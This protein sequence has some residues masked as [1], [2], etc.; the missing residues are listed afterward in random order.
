MTVRVL[1]ATEALVIG[2][3]DLAGAEHH[4]VARVR[5]A[6][7]GDP[8]AA[9]DGAGRV[10]TGAIVA[11]DADRTRIRLDRVVAEPAPVPRITA[12]IPLI[13]GDR[14]DL[15][16]EKLAEV[17]VDAIVLY[18]AA[19]AVVR[20]DDDRAATRRDRLAA[21]A[22]AATRQSGRGAAPVVTGP[23]PLAAALGTVAGHDLRWVA[24]PAAD[25]P[26]RPA[27]PPA[28]LAIL[29]GP[30]GGL[31]ADELAAAA[32]AGF[33]TVGLGPYVLRAE[34]AP[35]VAAAHARLLCAT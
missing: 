3:L 16:V 33:V 35:I 22:E 4:Y 11:I 2:E 29:T 10:G 1:V 20:L 34:T 9:V 13:K 31:T 32:A 30:E 19:R 26:A 7:V 12:L 21:V 23:M 14:L 25:P 8:I 17:G 28:T 27:T 18:V 6:A 15:C 24:M 5:R